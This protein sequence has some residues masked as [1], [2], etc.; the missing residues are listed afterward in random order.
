MLRFSG[1]RLQ[2]IR[3]QNRVTQFQMA[4]DL[5][6]GVASLSRWENNTNM[7]LLTELY[8]VARYCKVPMEYFVVND[9]GRNKKQKR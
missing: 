8:K 9:E 5:D 4:K 3:L 6:L 7:P 1:E 2:A